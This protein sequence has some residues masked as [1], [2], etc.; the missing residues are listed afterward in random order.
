MEGNPG[1]KAPQL[2]TSSSGEEHGLQN[3]EARLDTAARLHARSALADGSARRLLS[4][5]VKDRH[6]PGA[7]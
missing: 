4:G 2:M 6:L 1:E 7:P 3:R 5:D